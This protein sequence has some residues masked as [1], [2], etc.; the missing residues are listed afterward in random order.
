MT[1]FIA[2]RT[3]P[4][5]FWNSVK[6]A[7][8]VSALA[9]SAQAAPAASPVPSPAAPAQKAPAH[10]PRAGSDDA[11]RKASIAWK[12][13]GNAEKYEF[14]LATSP[15]MDPVLDKKEYTT[16]STQLLLKPGVYY[17]RVRGI[18]KTD[19]P[20]PWSDIQ[21]FAVNP[22]PPQLLG[23]TDKA[24][25]AQRLPKEGVK[26]SWKA[27]VKGSK[28]L[29][30]IRDSQGVLL[31]RNVTGTE[32]LWIPS[33]AKKYAW[34]V[35]FETPTGEEWSKYNVVEVDPKALAAPVTAAPVAVASVS[36]SAEDPIPNLE[37][38]QQLVFRKELS[39]TRSSEWSVLGRVAQAVAAYSGE[40]KDLNR[41]SSGS[42]G[43][44]FVSAALRS[45]GGRSPEQRWTW[46]GSLNF[47]MIRQNVLNELFQ[48]PRFY[49][50]LFYAKEEGQ[51]RAGP[52][53][54]LYTGQSGV[55]IVTGSTS[56]RKGTVSRKSIG[57]GG[58]VVYRPTPSMSLS[59]LLTLRMDTGGDA[60]VTPTALNNTLGYEAGFGSVLGLSQKLFLEARLRALKESLEWNP[61][62]GGSQAS[63]YNTLFIILD[64][65]VG[66]RL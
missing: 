31:K 24:V 8:L 11:P 42:G 51:W 5:P 59:G 63:Y 35:G 34:R 44:G 57:A 23:P 40:D 14:E 6:L 13:V 9:A 38:A 30:E 21:G 22:Q 3:T 60:G 45:R 43:G 53:L 16:T 28:Y 26:F 58:V 18:D 4:C 7:G 46:S 52:F 54:Q 66:F 50:R 37:K 36:K 55:F 61:T 49:G 2:R 1:R 27:G 56:A 12:P 20:G 62:N 25:L 19:S 65:G 39:E 64:L 41:P 29:I 17:F 47:E 33:D 48:M 10:A 32:Y 15:E